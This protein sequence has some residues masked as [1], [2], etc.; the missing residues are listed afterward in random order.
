MNQVIFEDFVIITTS[1]LSLSAAIGLAF[2]VV[3]Q[4]HRESANSWFGLFLASLALWSGAALVLALPMLRVGLDLKTGFYLYVAGLGLIPVTFYFAAIAFCGIRSLFTRLI[5][6]LTPVILVIMLVLLWTDRLFILDIPPATSAITFSTLVDSVHTQ[7]TG[8]VAILLSIAYLLITLIL[9]WRKRGERNRMLRIPALLLCIGSMGNLAEPFNRIPLDAVLTTLAAGLIG[10]VLIRVQLFDPL[11]TMNRQLTDANQELRLLIKD[12]AAEKERADTLNA[13]LRTVSQYKS[14]FLAT[15]SHELRT[16]LN[17]I[18]GYSELLL[19]GLYGEINERQADRL[20]KILRNG[21]ALL[22]LINNILDLSKIEAG[23]ME[24][25][26]QHLALTDIVKDVSA[27]FATAAE[28]KGLQLKIRVEPDLPFIYGDSLRVQQILSNLL[29]NAVK[30]TLQGSIRL[31]V[32]SAQVKNGYCRTPTLPAQ[33]WLKDGD[34]VIIQVTDTGI[35]IAPEDHARIFDEFRQLDGTAT[36]EFGGT[37]LGLAITRKLVA[38]H[39]G[40]IWLTSAPDQGSTFFVALPAS[41]RAIIKAEPQ[42]GA[43]PARPD[44]PHILIIDDNQEALDIL[45]TYLTGAGYRVTEASDGAKGLELARQ[46]QPDIITTDLMMPGMTGWEVI[47]Q[48]RAD[49]ATAAIPI[50]TVSIVDNQPM[51]L[52]PAVDAHISKPIHREAL[53]EAIARLLTGKPGDR[54]ILIV[55]DDPYARQLVAD[56]LTTAG[57]TSVAVDGGQA[58]IDWLS[59]N[60]ASAVV[61]D[62]LMPDVNGF[63]VLEHIRQQAYLTDL[64]VLVVTAKTLT[65]QEQVF[66]QD[67]FATLVRKQGLQRGDL[68]VLIEQVLSRPPA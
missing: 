38:L 40:T 57:H 2:G 39:G 10:Y 23:R 26:L 19:Q 13:E 42:S 21:Q 65:A 32:F 62:L 63:Q 11:A 29:S 59:H 55:D 64:P 35:G 31:E 20:E 6:L 36:R 48:L 7:P 46:L 33:G 17:S 47:E 12:L 1:I 18:V 24:L 15:M 8:T 44:Q 5:G 43:P 27:D 28:A 51:G 54:P 50:V 67:H 66:L 34:W 14:E 16:P 37:G 68:L 4:P 60:R 53:L 45:T 58:A 30:F 9:I 41:R 3:F 22:A 52:W 56:V 49:P 25:A 61:L